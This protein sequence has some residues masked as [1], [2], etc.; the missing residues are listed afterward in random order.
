MHFPD[1]DLADRK[2]NWE[3]DKKLIFYFF[4][5][6][7]P[8]LSYIILAL[9]L[10]IIST[11]LEVYLPVLYKSSIDK[12]IAHVPI[13][14]KSKDIK[15]IYVPKTKKAINLLNR[16]NIGY[17]I[18]S[19]LIVL[20]VY[21]YRKMSKKDI[22]ILRKQDL[23]KLKQLFFLYTAILFLN[24]LFS[25]IRN[26]LLGK[27]S[28]S[29]IF[30][31]RRAMFKKYMKQNM[32]F[33]SKNPLGRLVTRIS[34]DIE[35]INE[36]ITNVSV[37]TINDI[38]LIIG[39]II[40]MLYLNIRLALVVLMFFPVLIF[41]AGVFS[42]KWRVLYRESRTQLSRINS[43]LSE[44]LGMI[45]FIK[46]I[47]YEKKA[48]DAFMERI[49][50]LFEANFNIRLSY[51]L[52]SPSIRFMRDL[53]TAIFIVYGGMMVLNNRLSIG[54]IVAFVSYVSML[55]NPIRDMVDKFNIIQASIAAMEKVYN[56]IED[57]NEEIDNG[58]VVLNEIMG[59][60]EFKNVWFR[61]DREWILRGI[62]F[63]IKPGEK[64]AIVGYTGEGKSTII[65][66][67]LRFYEPHKGK[68]LLDNV[69]INNFK[70]SNYREYFSLVQQDV[71]AFSD[72]IS[73]NI[74]FG[75]ID[76]E[77]LKKSL[78][79]VQIYNKVLEFKDGVNTELTEN[80]TNISI[81]ERQLLSFARAVYKDAR[82]LFL[83][84]ATS[85]IDSI[86]E[87]KIQRL[88]FDVFRDKT[89]IIIAH[90]L[91]TIKHVD[92]ILVL[93]RGK[94]V[95]SGSHIELLKKGGIYYKLYRL[96][97]IDNKKN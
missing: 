84:E 45:E 11:G 75:A 44:H 32:Y 92:K 55:F 41:L 53:T 5:F 28:Q 17:K 12:Y 31:L 70:L 91:A 85:N 18:N 94:I 50:M 23:I 22:E 27:T 33:Y 43:F 66:L 49:N 52:F 80:A 51:A 21:D 82:I 73:S 19:H 35:A 26:Y 7:K 65:N 89:M 63:S 6:L 4:K 72:T 71:T 3:N 30:D 13:N 78:S 37:F 61:Y 57:E 24:L 15:K 97:F 95:E 77:R 68:I 10:L 56:I 83:D 34:N 39:A 16:L 1:I 9:I 62:N 60:I 42:K 64:V 93:F 2:I 87:N 14:K 20:D 74:H 79:T 46:L 29:F 25:A 8:Y 88:L 69:P 90:R 36:M 38:V 54:T 48:I 59:S 76:D 47:S 40:A 67:I 58:E 86:T 96:Q 81:G